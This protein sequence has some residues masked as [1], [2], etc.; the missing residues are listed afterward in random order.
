M[1]KLE[2]SVEKSLYALTLTANQPESLVRFSP[3]IEV[4]MLL[5]FV[6]ERYDRRDRV[7]HLMGHHLKNA[8]IVKLSLLDF[9]LIRAVKLHN[10]VHRTA[11]AA[12]LGAGAGEVE[13]HRGIVGLK[14]AH[15]GAHHAHQ[16]PHKRRKTQQAH[17]K[18]QT[19][20]HRLRHKA[21]HE[22]PRHR[23]SRE[24]D[25]SQQ[26]G[27]TEPEPSHIFLSIL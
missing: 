5:Q 11:H 16:A 19:C 7:A 3:G 6:G 17:R 18:Q 26:K 12:Q 21:R 4:R 2:V 9:G 27:I 14:G 20:G 13:S 15:K 8:V 25:G 22:K 23:A 1:R 24:N 10:S